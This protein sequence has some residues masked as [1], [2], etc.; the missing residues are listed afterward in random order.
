MW[1]GSKG[2]LFH[3]RRQAQALAKCEQMKMETV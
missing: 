1:L 3:P 2:A